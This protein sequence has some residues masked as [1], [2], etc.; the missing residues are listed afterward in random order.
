M[1]TIGPFSLEE[2][3]LNKYSKERKDRL[4][5]SNILDEKGFIEK[6]KAFLEKRF[7]TKIFVYSEDDKDRYDPKNRAKLAIPGQPAIF[8]M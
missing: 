7:K 6:A 3:F 5:N 2:Y 8:I 4:N 1:T